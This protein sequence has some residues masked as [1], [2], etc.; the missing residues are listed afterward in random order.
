[1]RLRG[2]DATKPEDAEMFL[3]EQNDFS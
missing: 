2:T 3:D 1:M